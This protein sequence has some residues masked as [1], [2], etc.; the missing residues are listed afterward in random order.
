MLHFQR[1]VLAPHPRKEPRLL[2]SQTLLSRP[3]P[4]AR[5]SYKHQA[6][7]AFFCPSCAC[8]S[9]DTTTASSWPWTSRLHAVGP[10]STAHTGG[11]KPSETR[12]SQQR[13]V[14]RDRAESCNTVD[15]WHVC[16]KKCWGKMNNAPKFL[17]KAV[18]SPHLCAR[19]SI[20]HLSHHR[21]CRA[22]PTLGR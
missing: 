8:V 7:A 17:D 15:S 4:I 10:K 1:L 5:T 20:E 11:F 9:W 21:F 14:G 22:P 18:C 6:N 2:L 3:A 16:R 13:M 19:P 12:Y